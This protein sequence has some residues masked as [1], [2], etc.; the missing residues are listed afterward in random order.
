MAEWGFFRGRLLTR[1]F[2]ANL[3]HRPYNNAQGVAAYRIR[4]SICQL[5]FHLLFSGKRSSFGC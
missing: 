5:S 2:Q 4:V 1:S 3:D